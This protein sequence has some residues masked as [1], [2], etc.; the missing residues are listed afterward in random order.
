MSEYLL[1]CS[2]LAKSVDYLH[3]KRVKLG[4]ITS[5]VSRGNLISSQN[6]Y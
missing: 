4:E 5:Q 1:D 2:N 3:A 6:G